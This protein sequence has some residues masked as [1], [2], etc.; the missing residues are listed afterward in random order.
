MNYLILV[1]LWTIFILYIGF[2]F[3]R[4]RNNCLPLQDS[5]LCT[6]FEI[7]RSIQTDDGIIHLIELLPLR[8]LIIARF[9]KDRDP[10]RLLADFEEATIHIL[11]K[12]KDYE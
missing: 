2:I 6:D 4:I 1:C 5:D 10:D 9:N 11:E 7:K 3:G 12:G 8:E